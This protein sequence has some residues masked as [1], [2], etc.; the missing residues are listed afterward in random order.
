MAT[1]VTARAITVR[2]RYWWVPYLY[3]LRVQILTASI[4]LIGP[5]VAL[6]SPLLRGLFDLDYGAWWRTVFGVAFVTLAA[7]ASA[8]TLMATTWATIFHAPARFNTARINRVRYPITWPN[9]EVFGVVAL[10][11]VLAVVIYTWRASGVSL[12]VLVLGVCVGLAGAIA[13][14]LAARGSAARLDRAV[15]QDVSQAL[16]IRFLRWVVHQLDRP[17]VR[18]GFV[19]AKTHALE[20]GHMLAWVVFTFSA[21]L[22]AA[23]GVGKWV[24]IGYQTNV[25]TL[26]CVLLLVLMA[27]WLLVGLTFFLDK[28]RVSAVLVLAGVAFVIALLP[29]PGS[30]NVYR[31]WP[32]VFDPSPRPDQVLSIGSRTPI[33][34]AATGGGIQAAA[35]TAR[36]LTG[37]DSAL[38]GD[39]RDAFTHSIRL[40][41]TVSGGGVGAMYFSERY[42]D[43]GFDRRQL[44][45][46][47]AKAEASSLDDVAWGAAYPDALAIFVPPVRALLGDRGQ[48]LEWAWTRSLEVARPVSTW[49]TQVWK[50]IRPANIFNATLVDSG[51]RLLIGTSRLGWHWHADERGLRNFEDLPNFEETYQDRDLQVVTAARLAASFTYV[52]PATRTSERGPAHHVVDG[53]YYDDYGMTTLAEWLHEGLIGVGAATSFPRVLVIQIRSDPG[54]PTSPPDRWHG[55]FYQLLAPAET[56]IN[57]RSTAQISHNNEELGLLQQLEKTKGV[58]IDNVVFRFCG[59]HPIQ[60]EWMTH[61]RNRHEIRAVEE[62]LRGLPFSGVKADKPYDA[63]LDDC[64]PVAPSRWERLQDL[65]LH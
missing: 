13:G 53:G 55:P 34:I 44:E 35:W 51:E 8:W 21:A 26:A 9:R 12:W 22:Y 33:L 50:D 47:V 62:F 49:R 17:N 63:P 27:C 30:E 45:E 16:V 29:L 65:V 43:D 60:T 54:K 38:P 11:T 4:L 31:T 59:E 18:E 58:E 5:P 24:R 3:L 46:V 32:S 23:I 7:F 39:L 10:P 36:V 37:L 6:L 28:Y 2:S 64:P 14:L 61:V 52:S 15:R 56:L 40:M 41:S 1:V 42:T 48:A 57:V 20:E 25:S 19:D